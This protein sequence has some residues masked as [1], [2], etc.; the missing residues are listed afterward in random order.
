M[1]PVR[2]PWLPPGGNKNYRYRAP[3]N[4]RARPD[5]ILRTVLKK[6]E[7]DTERMRQRKADKGKLRVLSWLS[8][9]V[10]RNALPSSCPALCN[11]ARIYI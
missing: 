7:A 4:F 2:V 6:E 9:V 1:R 10:Y 5:A 8:V 3:L 11:L